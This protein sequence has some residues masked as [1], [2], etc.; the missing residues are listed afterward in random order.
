MCLP[1]GGENAVFDWD[2]AGGTCE[3]HYNLYDDMSP[4]DLCYATRSVWGNSWNERVACEI[5]P[6]CQW[7]YDWGTC[8]GASQLSYDDLTAGCVDLGP[9]YSAGACEYN[10]EEASMSNATNPSWAEIDA[11]PAEAAALVPGR[12]LCRWNSNGGIAPSEQR[13]FDA[14]SFPKENPTTSF[15]LAGASYTCPEYVCVS[16]EGQADCDADPECS[17]LPW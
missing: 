9:G 1:P 12:F 11:N 3:P 14:L 4:E 8:V 7:N 16:D 15:D 13:A 6:G 5:L 10:L 2:T 17:G